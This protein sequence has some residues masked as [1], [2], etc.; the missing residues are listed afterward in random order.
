MTTYAL[1][2][3]SIP[4]GFLTDSNIMVVQDSITAEIARFYNAYVVRIPKQ[5]VV[6]IMIHAMEKRRESVPKMNRASV[7]NAS[8]AFINFVS[9]NERSNYFANNIW[10][11]YNRVN[12]GIKPYS[13]IRMNTAESLGERPALRFHYSY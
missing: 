2:T 3:H 7:I 12:L 11:A 13:Q 10:N 6:R 5:D 1:W 9:E 4:H 8:R